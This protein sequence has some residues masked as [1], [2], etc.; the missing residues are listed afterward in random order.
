MENSP[1]QTL[2]KKKV[3]VTNPVRTRK[4][5]TEDDIRL[6]AFQIYIECDGY[7]SEFD[8]WIRAERELKA[9]YN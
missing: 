6:R 4:I 3:L 9:D 8:N 5:I 7:S 2:S 1:L